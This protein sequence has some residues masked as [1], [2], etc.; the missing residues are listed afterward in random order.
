M[1]CEDLLKGELLNSRLS[2]VRDVHLREKFKN[3]ERYFVSMKIYQE[4]QMYTIS[5]ILIPETLIGDKS[6]SSYFILNNS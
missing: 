2:S 3:I 6:V 4:V 1:G 5:I